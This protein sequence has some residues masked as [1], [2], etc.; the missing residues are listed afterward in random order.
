M[1]QYYHP[2]DVSVSERNALTDIYNSTN[3]AGWTSSDNWT[4]GGYVASS[5]H[6]VTV[7]NGH[8]SKLS[9]NANNLNGSIPATITNLP[10]LEEINFSSNNLNGSVP[11]LTTI[12]TLSNVNINGNDFSFAD[13]ETNYTNNSSISSF[14]YQIQKKRDTED[15]FDGTIGNNYSLTMSP[16]SGTNV[17]YQWY[18]K[19]LNYFDES[20]ESITGETNNTLSFT[21]LQDS[22]MDI[23]FCRATS[24]AIP[25][26]IIERNS[27][28]IKGPVSQLQ[29][30][31]LIA[32]YNSTNGAS[33][34]DNTN[35]L[36]T[37]PVSE[38]YGV[39]V[40]GNKITKL[41]LPNNNLTGTLPPEIGNLTG[42]ESLWLFNGNSINGTLPPEI[43]NL[44]E[45]RVLS[46]ENN[47][48]TGE[49]PPSY[50]NLTNLRGFWFN[51]NQLSGNIP[52][53]VATNYP[54]L[55]FFDI[56]FN[57]FDGTL[58]DF[59]PLQK[60]RYIAIGN[61]HFFPG[62]FSAQFND[63]LN[64]Q[65]NMN[66]SDF[67][68]WSSSY[69]YTPQYTID[70]IDEANGT[71]G[72]NI[73]LTLTDNSSSRL[74]SS[75]TL[76]IDTYQ[77]FKDDVLISGATAS[78]YTITNAQVA[79]SGVYHCE[80]SNTDVPDLV[81]L[82]QDVTVTVGTLG[83]DDNEL[84][85]ISIYPNPVK[86]TFNITMRNYEN[87][88]ASL[89]DLRGRLILNQKLDSELTIVN[90]SNLNDGIYVLNIE[91]KTGKVTKRIIKK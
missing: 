82:R 1:D 70:S 60:I 74:S 43:G 32:I 63:Y 25:D 49:I 73:T 30:D 9:L 22:D 19:R 61:N 48:F 34:T 38:W 64:S 31:A 35:W 6:G 12:T 59:T 40:T 79:D 89:Y 3:G 16:I 23:Y 62:D 20:D 41:D 76:A 90:I 13:I 52:A 54:N 15:S 17:Q 69:F 71:E 57:D 84:Q 8:V 91:N 77:W 51:D 46:V 72:D 14:I 26:L 4:L 78:S 66:N 50:S 47:N 42:L 2:Q 27:I 53:F 75:S 28:E 67:Y 55:V 85:S 83:I 18:K 88:S 37:E 11:N 24:T 65:T 86:E 39:T 10:Y 36:T 45:L 87:A 21:S 33:W 68:S 58:P 5:W 56:S 44:T 29:K 81:V 80:I 7:K